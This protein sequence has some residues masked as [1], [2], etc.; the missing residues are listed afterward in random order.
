MGR[1]L[2]PLIEHIRQKG[3]PAGLRWA[4]HDRGREVYRFGDGVPESAVEILNKAGLTAITSRSELAIAEAYIRGDIDLSGDV[5]KLMELRHLVSDRRWAPAVWT[6]LQ[7]VLIGRKR[8]NPGW[9]AKHYDS[10]NMQLLALDS[11]YAVYTPG[12]YEHDGDTL[13][14][15]AERKLASA[16]GSLGLTP[17]SRLLDV[18]CGWGGF[19]RYCARRGVDAT[20]ITL[21]R[22]QYD[23]VANKLREDRLDARVKYQDFFTFEPGCKYDAVSLMG[24]LEDLSDYDRV[25]ARLRAWLRP[26]GHV[27]CDFASAM[28]RYGVPSLVTK[29]VWPGRFRMVYM[30]QFVRALTSHGFEILEIH[31][32]RHNYYLWTK[33]LHERW[34]ARHEEVLQV[35]DEATW[36]LMRLLMVGTGQVMGPAA[37]RD[38]AFRV[39][40]GQRLSSASREGQQP[41]AC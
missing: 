21:S 37:T 35:A 31:N 8:S 19:L 11:E 10:N 24:V 39:L 34:V 33:A 1:K 22:H 36:R 40:L 17:G 16:F 38:T 14:C 5:F 23:Y 13:E 7:S 26:G 2:E 32:D 25:M 4:L 3:S 12:L 20:G 28:R 30:P 29:H 6:F 41:A 9:I 15:G 18:G 27:Y